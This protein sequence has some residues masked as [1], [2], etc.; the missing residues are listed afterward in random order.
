MEPRFQQTC[1]RREEVRS[2]T[3]WLVGVAVVWALSVTAALAEGDKR[4][5]SADR[6]A[7]CEREAKGLKAEERERFLAECARGE[8]H[9]V[10]S[11]QEKMKHC[12][13][14]ARE[15]ELRGDE[16]RAFMSSCLKG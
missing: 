15:R 4:A 16:R 9:G 2:K 11:Q 5:A 14:E 13:H 7:S 3:V 1:R 8:S 10:H 6:A 12:N